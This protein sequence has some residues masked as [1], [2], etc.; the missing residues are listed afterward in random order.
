MYTHWENARS[1]N[2]KKNYWATST[3]PFFSLLFF[4][5]T[6]FFSFFSFLSVLWMVASL[7]LYNCV[8]IYIYIIWVIYHFNFLSFS[9][10]L[11]FALILYWSGAQRAKCMYLT[12]SLKK[13]CYNLYNFRLCLFILRSST[14]TTTTKKKWIKIFGAY[15]T[16]GC[17]Q[18]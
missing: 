8:C 5:C 15:F 7:G 18:A 14:T 3:H 16:Q 1:Q 6:F 13:W 4:L 10:G 12:R 2:D 17:F 9:F 11:W